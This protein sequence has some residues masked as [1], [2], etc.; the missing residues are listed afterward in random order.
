VVHNKHRE[1][2]NKKR[3]KGVDL[4]ED[5]TVSEDFNRDCDRALREQKAHFDQ[6]VIFWQNSQ[7]YND[8]HI[9]VV[10]KIRNI[11]VPSKTVVMCPPHDQHYK[12]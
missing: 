3:G 12:S 2:V 11:V 8:K 9:C 1:Q 7:Q 6:A 10:A 4:M 5:K